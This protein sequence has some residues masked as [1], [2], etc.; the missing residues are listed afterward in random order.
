M[1][2][3]KWQTKAYQKSQFESDWSAADKEGLDRWIL[4]HCL[5]KDALMGLSDEDA[6]AALAAARWQ[7]LPRLDPDQVCMYVCGWVGGWVG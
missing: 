1:D 2:F 7:L 3:G 6:A 4:A 5:P